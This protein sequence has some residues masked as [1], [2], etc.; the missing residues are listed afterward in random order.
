MSTVADLP[1]RLREAVTKEFQGEAIR[2][3]GRPS[4]GRVLA[5]SLLIWLFAV[6]WTA[7][8]IAWV[9]MAG[10]SWLSATPSIRSLHGLTGVAFPLFGMP[11]V[12]VGL[13]MMAAPVIAW[14]WARHTVHV[15][16]QKRFATVTASRRLLKVKS[17]PIGQIVRTERIEKRNGSGTLKVVTG[18]R[19]DSEGDKVE[20]TEVLYGIADVAKV[21]RLLTAQIDAERRAA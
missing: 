11:F 14:A 20:D 18:T 17:Y 7:F 12:M 21:D 13:I 6:P 10:Q 2:W 3:V 16:G 1:R 4:A 9:I 8:S 19:R 5:T 15:I